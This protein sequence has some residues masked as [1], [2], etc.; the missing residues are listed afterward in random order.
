MKTTAVPVKAVRNP[1][2]GGV[3]AAFPEIGKLVHDIE[4]R[5]FERFASRGYGFGHD[6]DDWLAAESEVAVVPA[7]ELVETES[8]YKVDVALPGIPADKLQVDVTPGC[9]VVEGETSGRKLFRKFEF[10]APID[11]DKVTARLARGMLHVTAGK[12]APELPKRVKV[13]VA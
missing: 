12:A 11:V 13:A 4:Q 6:L 1:P 2:E 5:A 9:I 10:S 8:E 3:L 7:A